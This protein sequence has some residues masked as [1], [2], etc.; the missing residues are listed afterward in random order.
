M[1]SDHLICNKKIMLHIKVEYY[2]STKTNYHPEWVAANVD[3]VYWTFS[4]WSV[5]KFQA[6]NMHL[7]IL[8]AVEL[9]H[10]SYRH[11]HSIYFQFYTHSPIDFCRQKLLRVVEAQ[12]LYH[13]NHINQYLS[14]QI[15]NPFRLDYIEHYHL[16]NVCY[17]YQTISDRSDHNHW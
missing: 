14:K 15:S 12:V 16:W 5:L 3:N 10:I 2:S 13:R 4:L 11:T 6:H 9:V 1:L 17:F 7:Y 8:P